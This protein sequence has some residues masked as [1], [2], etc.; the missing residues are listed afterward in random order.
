MSEPQSIE[1]GP[2]RRVLSNRQVLAFIAGR[3]MRRPGR[4]FASIALMLCAVGA[5]LM[6]PWASG[7][8]VNAVAKGPAVAADDALRAWMAFVGVYLLF[9]VARNIA[10]RVWNPFAARNMEELTNDAFDRVQAFSSD[11]HADT[12]AGATVRRV[13]RAM[14]GY[15]AVSDSV[16]L[17]LGSALLVL[18]G[19]SISMLIR[20][21]V[22]G[23][24]A[25]A[26]IVLYLA[27]N[28]VLTARY[29]R[30]AN[31]VSNARDSAIGAALADSITGNAAVKSFGPSSASWSASPP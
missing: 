9:F 8:L 26:V 28:V 10:F 31:L 30:P 20:W 18:I 22:V 4:F 13:S 23:L 11:W 12:F 16:V 15:D 17:W 27:L 6:L 7:A 25:S 29:V 3:W 14:W 5:D 2:R 24:F 19:L 1:E 21:P